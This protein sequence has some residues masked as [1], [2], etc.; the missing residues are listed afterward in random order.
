[1]KFKISK[2]VEEAESR[3]HGTWQSS[4]YVMSDEEA[5]RNVRYS[6]PTPFAQ[7]IIMIK[8]Q[9]QI[10]SK[11]KGVYALLVMAV[12][13]PILYLLLKDIINM[14]GLKTLLYDGSANGMVGLMLSMMPFILGVFTSSLCGKLMPKEFI[15]R[16]AYMN[17]ALPI[18]RTTFV[19][20]KYIASL[21]VTIGVVIFAYGMALVTSAMEFEYFNT[22]LLL[23][24]FVLTIV[25]VMVF[26]STAFAFGCIVKKGAGILSFFLLVI[27]IPIIELIFF[28]NKMMSLETMYYF[29]N[30]LADLCC[31]IM[32]TNVTGSVLGFFGFAGMA[33]DPYT[34]SLPLGAALGLI[35]S[36]I[37]IAIALVAV[38][39][40]EM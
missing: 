37:M 18:S 23:V 3:P 36:A 13:I 40:R 2:E 11:S 19:I 15:D 25:A 30:A 26:T 10:F 9:M 32:G 28:T 14:P 29:P 1:M 24:S 34:Y 4:D 22:H 35:W 7:T 20:G 31:Q 5:H 27:V 17:M 39:R 12:L 6:I 8:S 16:T 38:N 33:F 21:I